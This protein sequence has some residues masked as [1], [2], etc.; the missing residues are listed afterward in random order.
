MKKAAIRVP[1]RFDAA[2][3]IERETDGSELGRLTFSNVDSARA[4]PLVDFGG[5]SF[6]IRSTAGEIVFDSGSQLDAA[7]ISLGIY[8]DARS[9]NKGV[10]PEGVTLLQVKGRV[11]AFVGMERT[12]TAA[13]AVYDVTSPAAVESVD[14]IV[15]PNDVSTEGLTA[16]RVGSR[17]FV[18]IANEVSNSTSLFEVTVRKGSER[19]E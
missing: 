9:D 17:Y 15:S 1:A 3:K 13:F 7:A 12:S 19:A 8:D 16:F 4:G 6:S 10:E 2:A 14:T 18:A 11:L 5:R